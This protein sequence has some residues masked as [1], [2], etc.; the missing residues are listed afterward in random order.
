MANVFSTGIAYTYGSIDTAGDGSSDPGVVASGY[1]FPLVLKR[2][3]TCSIEVFNS[4][5]TT[6]AHVLM[7][8]PVSDTYIAVE[9]GDFATATTKTFTAPRDC[10]VIIGVANGVDITG[11]VKVKLGVK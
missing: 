5:F 6:T 4:G 11:T 9:D 3:D 10:K 2:G 1:T 7:Y 8:E